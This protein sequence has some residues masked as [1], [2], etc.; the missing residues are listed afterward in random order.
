MKRLFPL[1]AVF[2]LL[3]VALAAQ[4]RRPVPIGETSELPLRV[5]ARPLSS[6]YKDASEQNVVRSNVPAFQSYFVYTRPQGEV[7]DSGLGW[8]EVGTDEKGTV[9]GWMKAD[10]VFEWRQTMCLF[11]T[12]PEGRQPV[13]MFEEEE[14]LLKLV[15]ET[16]DK[17]KVDAEGYYQA[18]TTASEGGAL[19]AKDFPVISI[20]PKMAVDVTKQFYFLP[21]LEH[22]EMILDGREGRILR[23]AA[24]SGSGEDARKE[25]D[26]RSNPDYI[27]GATVDSVDHAQML[28]TAHIDFVWLIDTTRSMAPY[29]AKAQDVMRQISQELAANPNL[30]DR[31]RF[32]VWAYRDSV[33]IPNIEYLTKNFTPTL[34]P[35]EEF[36]PTMDKVEE[37]KT[38]SVDM[39][40]DVFAGVTDA[41]K[42]TAWRANSIR[43]MVLVGD[44]PSHEPGHK[45]NST[46]KNEEDLRVELSASK[47]NF[48]AMH[49]QPPTAKRFNKVSKQQF[50]ALATNPGVEKPAYWAINANDIALFAS[51]SQQIANIVVQFVEAG[52]EMFVD[53]TKQAS[54]SAEASKALTHVKEDQ[55]SDED[56]KNM[57]KAA[58]V[59]WI[60][61][62]ANAM[63][64]RDI[65]AWVVD[66]DLLNPVTH[67][68]EINLLIN[69]RQ[70]DS[71]S[72]L[73]AEVLDAGKSN[74]MSGDDFF[75]SLQAASVMASRNPDMLAHAPNL[76][77]SGLIPDFL[78]GLP[79]Y[80][81]L[82]SMNN[83]LWASWGPD[84]QDDFLN[85]IVS[86]IQ[87]YRSLHDNPAI[88]VP[89]NVGDDPS[90]FVT[91]VPLELLP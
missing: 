41:I 55:L 79:Y 38:D 76:A 44:A 75:A 63:P 56:L 16:A 17:R 37:T 67:S 90:E 91:P 83:D 65:E 72:T 88:W 3:P 89:L 51:A 87:T 36:L 53:G 42:S 11:Y 29:I 30:K 71:L 40:E 10:D 47:I 22:R 4:E 2:L 81:Q 9:V 46:G 8:Y 62:Q 15:N 14:A 54:P 60:G 49:V 28:K 12:H 85:G 35:I 1:F 39:P 70:L 66:K 57:L 18:I 13:L 64:P 78:A 43:I 5:L 52:D 84:E 69:K 24:V 21:I 33:E 73:L 20:E 50:S 48:V 77:Q 59:T 27:K 25:S 7:L 34:L 32:G 26:I 19:L 23:V 61:S 82:M 86:K 58:A 68:L 45:W 31:I 6:L 80:S 74:Q